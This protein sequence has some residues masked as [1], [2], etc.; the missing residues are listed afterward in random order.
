MYK[1]WHG[2]IPR[3]RQACHF[4]S[5]ISSIHRETNYGGMG[6]GSSSPSICLFV[7]LTQLKTNDQVFKLGIGNEYCNKFNTGRHL[8]AVC[9]T[10][11][12]ASETTRDTIALHNQRQRCWLI[13]LSGSVLRYFTAA[14]GRYPILLPGSWST[15]CQRL[16]TV[17]PS[18]ESAIA[19]GRHR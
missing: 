3:T 18:R 17:L 9:D 10:T 4:R 15:P 7:C 5:I 12:T 6:I 16:L 1:F 2:H 19:K 11:L 13:T 14:F 8:T